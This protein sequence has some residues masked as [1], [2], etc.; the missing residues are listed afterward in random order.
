MVSTAAAWHLCLLA[1]T[2]ALGTPGPYGAVGW[3]SSLPPR[4]PSCPKWAR[5]F[6]TGVKS[7]IRGEPEMK[8]LM[9]VCTDPDK[10]TDKENE[11]D[12]D[13]WVAKHDASGQRLQGMV[14]APKSTAT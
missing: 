12:I 4:A 5:P 8:Y 6:V 1:A 3:T 11:P 2:P 9:F 13:E 14:L 10:D 7:T